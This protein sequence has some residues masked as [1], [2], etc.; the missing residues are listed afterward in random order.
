MGS[1]KCP[2]SVTLVT[3]SS[4][5]ENSDLNGNIGIERETIPTASLSWDSLEWVS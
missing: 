1:E 5:H 4:M 3:T 2:K